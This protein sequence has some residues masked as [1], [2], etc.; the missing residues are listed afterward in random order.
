MNEGTEVQTITRILATKYN[1]LEE[2]IKLYNLQFNGDVSDNPI[3][4]EN[5]HTTLSSI[6]TDLSRP[7]IYFNIQ[8]TPPPLSSPPPSL[9]PL[10]ESEPG[11]ENSDMIEDRIEKLKCYLNEKK[12]ELSVNRKKISTAQTLRTTLESQIAALSSESQSR[13]CIFL[14]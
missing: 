14:Y 6:L 11:S 4:L 12:K 1:T 5:R 13:V 2:N 8:P 10:F 3:T 7:F 9:I